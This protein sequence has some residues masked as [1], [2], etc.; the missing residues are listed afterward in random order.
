LTIIALGTPMPTRSRAASK[1]L[2]AYEKQQVAEIAAWKS[3]PINP[4]AEAWN[5]VVLQAAKAV[6]FLVPDVV[7]RSAIELSY[8]AAHKLAPPQSIL[9]QAGVKDVRAIAPRSGSH[10]QRSRRSS[11]HQTPQLFV[12]STTKQVEALKAGSSSRRR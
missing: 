11:L 6:T 8:S 3:K 4:V 10:C 5:M 2:T 12:K 1:A 7:V 9:R